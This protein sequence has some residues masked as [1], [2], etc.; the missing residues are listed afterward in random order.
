[1]LAAPLIGRGGLVLKCILLVRGTWGRQGIVLRVRWSE[2]SEHKGP[3]RAI[4]SGG[5]NRTV[6]VWAGRSGSLPVGVVDESAEYLAATHFALAGVLGGSLRYR[7][8]Q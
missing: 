5:Q 3:A 7:Q 2:L 4:A 8:P 1:M 6:T